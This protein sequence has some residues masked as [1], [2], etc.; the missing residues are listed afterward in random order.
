M[1]EGEGERGEDIGEG[2]EFGAGN[3]GGERLLCGDNLVGDN[4]TSTIVSS[5]SSALKEGEECRL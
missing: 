2:E 4:G 5:I 3:I 1:G